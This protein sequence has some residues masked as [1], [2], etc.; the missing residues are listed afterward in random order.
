MGEKLE[1]IFTVNCAPASAETSS[2]LQGKAIP[3]W[4]SLIVAHVARG[5]SAQPLMNVIIKQVT[6]VQHIY[7]RGW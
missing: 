3:N 2:L 7:G 6:C 4:D 1:G 5:Y